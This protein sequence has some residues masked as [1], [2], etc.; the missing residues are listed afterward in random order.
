VGCIF[1]WMARLQ[2]FAPNTW[3]GQFQITMP[4]V[5]H[6]EDSP[7]AEHYLAILYRG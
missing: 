7:V 5:F 6:V 1:Y 2:N 4:G 3:V